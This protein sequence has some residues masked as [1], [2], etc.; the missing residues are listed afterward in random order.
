[1]KT[2]IVKPFIVNPDWTKWPKP[3]W[4]F[5]LWGGYL[6]VFGF[7]LQL[8]SLFGLDYSLTFVGLVTMFVGM[9][10][11]DVADFVRGT[12]VSHDEMKKRLAE[13]DDRIQK[14]EEQVAT[15]AAKLT[16][17]KHAA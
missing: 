2:F 4:K 13:Q 9:G 17:D 11:L 1:M 6:V 5:Y 12:N 3:H 7:G 14:L 16:P 10:V 15:L 8:G